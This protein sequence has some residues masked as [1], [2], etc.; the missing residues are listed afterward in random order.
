MVLNAKTSG[1][2]PL[3]D[4]H[5]VWASL[6]MWTGIIWPVGGIMVIVIGPVGHLMLSLSGRSQW[7]I[8]NINLDPNLTTKYRCEWGRHQQTTCQQLPFLS[9]DLNV[10][11][12]N[13]E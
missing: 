5:M 3:F 13:A 11:D 12:I 10:F 8:F 9:R 6:W 7:Y 2:I 1:C 4:F